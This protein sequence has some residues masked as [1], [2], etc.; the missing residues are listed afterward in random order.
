MKKALWFL[1]IILIVTVI[2]SRVPSVQAQPTA[3]IYPTQ[4]S[5]YTD[6]FLQVRG[7]GGQLDL[8]WDD[9]LIGV[10]DENF[11]GDMM[12]FDIH[13]SPP[14]EYPYSELGIHNVSVQIWW[15]HWD[16]EWYITEQ[17]FTLQF[18]IVDYY[19]PE[20]LFW[21]WWSNLDPEVQEQLRGPQGD[22]GP[23]GP[24][25]LQGEQGPDGPQGE[26]GAMGPQG[27]TGPPGPKGDQGEA[28]P[29]EGVAAN[30]GI[31]AITGVMAAI[32]LSMVLKLRG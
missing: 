12:G 2:I 3:D 11:Y 8:F 32:A 28:Y 15:R 19:P 20:D 22:P 24:Q 23:A 25:G 17:D 10:Y 5:I 6:I 4:G 21:E 7:I 16:G 13:F 18:E 26:Q 1:S 30:L 14:D 29:V 31:S 27:A 9:K